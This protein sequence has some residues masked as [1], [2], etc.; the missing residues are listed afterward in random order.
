[1][2]DINYGKIIIDALKKDVFSKRS[3]P[4]IGTL[5]IA[6][7][8]IFRLIIN[9]IPKFQDPFVDPL[10]IFINFLFLILMIIFIFLIFWIF[11]LFF[12]GIVIKQAGEDAKGIRISLKEGVGFIKNKIL[13]IVVAGILI[14]FIS[15]VIDSSV[16]NVPYMG[17][18]LYLV[19]S[20]LISLLVYVTYPYIILGDTGAIN[21]ISSSIQHFMEKKLQVFII[22][23]LE[24]VVSLVIIFIFTIPFILVFIVLIIPNLFIYTQKY[25]I[26]LERLSPLD[27]LLMEPVFIITI[28]T[29]IIS[30]IGIGLAMVFSYGVTAR[31]YNVAIEKIN[32]QE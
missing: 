32:G 13:S 9:L 12:G 2:S 16:Y 14:G 15:S 20:I 18:L 17:E 26:L 5:I 11:S 19:I 4:M 21:A 10:D 25:S 29:L 1:M 24:S 27:I 3:L 23:L 28:T 30:V 6:S 31:Y 8:L 22:W 7:A